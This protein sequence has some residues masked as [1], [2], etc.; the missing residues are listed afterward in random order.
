MLIA[1]FGIGALWRLR[2]QAEPIMQLAPAVADGRASR[3][4]VN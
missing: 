1:L 2:Q 3:K 4:E